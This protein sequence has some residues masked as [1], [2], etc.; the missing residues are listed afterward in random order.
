MSVN[1][2]DLYW[3]IESEISAPE[4]LRLWASEIAR[5]NPNLPHR[6]GPFTMANIEQ[7]KLDSGE[8]L[9]PGCG[10]PIRLPR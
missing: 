5:L 4:E 2:H 3:V 8:L 9:C 7:A 6:H 10:R 1:Y